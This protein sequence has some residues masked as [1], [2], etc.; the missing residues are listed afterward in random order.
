ML[1]ARLSGFVILYLNTCILDT[2]LDHNGILVVNISA[3]E[4]IKKVKWTMPRLTALPIYCACRASPSYGPT[5][6][7]KQAWPTEHEVE[8]SNP[9]PSSFE[10][11]L[12]FYLNLA[13]VF[14][15]LFESSI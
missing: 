14:R 4:Y 9:L 15:D 10:V 3:F 13:L 1:C 12:V 7:C 5:H 11:K 6:T 8:G 2:I